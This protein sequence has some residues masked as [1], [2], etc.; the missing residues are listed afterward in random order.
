MNALCGRRALVLALLL[1]SSPLWP[2]LA[3]PEE[4]R[5]GFYHGK[6]VPLAPL[7]EKAGGKM[8]A[9]AAPFWLALVADDGR[10]YPLLKDAGC[11]MFYKDPSLLHRPM[12]LTARPLGQ[13][14]ILQVFQ[15][16]SVRN[17]ELH[18]VYYW[19][20]VCQIKRFEKNACECCNGPMELREE[21]PR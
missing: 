13:T 16:H 17:G 7:L 2:A 15:V 1:G 8:D 5:V 10:I 4:P 18:E 6:V 20:D 11:R 3:G 19:C 12:R 21:K 9:D 14:N